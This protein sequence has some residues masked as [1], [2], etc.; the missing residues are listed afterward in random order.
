MDEEK[1]IALRAIWRAKMHVEPRALEQSSPAARERFEHVWH[2]AEEL[3]GDLL[4]FPR[5]ALRLWRDTAAGHIVFTA[6]GSR[7]APGRQVWRGRTLES[8]CFLSISDL[9]DDQH[10]A[11][12][13]LYALWDHLLGSRAVA[14]GSRFSQGA[15]A[16]ARLGDLA[17]RYVRLYGLGYGLCALGAFTPSDYFAQT[18][19]LYIAAPRHLDTID[20]LLYRLYHHELMREHVYD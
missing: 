11:M 13:T 1:K 17:G 14:G 4:P 7:Y 20:P 2:P 8:V 5:G 18:L 12:L 15:G 19:W 9:A 10:A 16:T 6:A 3:T